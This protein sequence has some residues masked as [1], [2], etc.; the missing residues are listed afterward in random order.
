MIH[1]W[2]DT[3][4]VGR[5][6]QPTLGL[7][8]DPHEFLKVMLAIG[9]GEIPFERKAWVKRLNDAHNSVM[10][11]MPVSANDGLVFGHVVEAINKH[12][13][14]DAVVT[15]DAG[16]FSSWPARFLHLGQENMFI[17]ATVGAMG[18]GVPSGVAAG[19]STPGRQIVVFVGDGGVMMT[20]NELATAVQYNVPIKIFIANNSAYGT[21]R[22]HQAKAFPGRV[23]ATALQNPDFVKWGEAFGAK[24]FLIETEGDVESV[25]AEA[26]AYDGPAV[27][28]SRISLNHISPAARI[29]EIEAR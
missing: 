1:V 27:I 24:G 26:M 10:D 14:K 3:E 28:E 5:V 18:P 22:M 9:P 7:G 12:L 17:G 19:L 20:G 4:E 15:T 13:T 2:P 23:T 25:V 6:F 29:D 21:I 8:C 16:N 11:W